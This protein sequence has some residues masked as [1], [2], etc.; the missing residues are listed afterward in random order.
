MLPRP[1]IGVAPEV[2]TRIHRLKNLTVGVRAGTGTRHYQVVKSA[3][4]DD[5]VFQSIKDGKLMSDQNVLK[6]HVQ[7]VARRLGPWFSNLS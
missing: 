7:P 3:R 2:I 1:R 5:F 4:P 6:R